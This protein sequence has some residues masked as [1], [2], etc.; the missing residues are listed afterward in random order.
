MSKLLVMDGIV[1][2]HVKIMVVQLKY[3]ID[4]I[5]TLG[6]IHVVKNVQLGIKIVILTKKKRAHIVTLNISVIEVMNNILNALLVCQEME[7]V[8][9]ITKLS[10]MLAW[11]RNINA[12]IP[13]IQSTPSA[14]SA[15]SKK[16][17]VLYTQKNAPPVSTFP[18]GSAMIRSHSPLDVKNVPLDKKGATLIKP[19]LAV[20]SARYPSLN[21]I[22]VIRTS[23][24]A[25]L[26]QLMRLRDVQT[27]LQHV[28]L[29]YHHKNIGAIEVM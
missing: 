13:Q 2:P 15:R 28:I 9:K 12:T 29:V 21:V 16:K 25:L 17:V 18:N 7:L 1:I 22:R 5:G 10:V 23:L 6:R 27:I 3:H 19:L 14:I 26:A 24:S 4:V 11:F 20:K 8:Q